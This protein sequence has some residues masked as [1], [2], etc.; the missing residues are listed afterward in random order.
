MSNIMVQGS[1][2]INLLQNGDNLNAS[3]VATAPLYQTFKKGTEDYSPNW[4]TMPD[5]DRPIVYPRVYSAMEAVVLPVTDI[6]WKFNA[7]AMTFDESRLC[8]YPEIAAGKIREIDYNG[9]K[10]LKIVGNLAS[11]INNDSDTISFV[12]NASA[13]GQQMTVSSEITILIEEA[14]SNLYRL[15]LNMT[16]DVIDGDEE[17]LLM[18]AKIY[19]LGAEVTS[20]VEY[21]FSKLD[22]TILRAK[23]SANFTITRAMIDSE[24]MIVCKAY[25]DNTVVAQGHRQVWDSTDPFTVYC[26]QG[27][28]VSQSSKV[29]TN[30]TFSLFNTRTGNVMS[31]ATFDIKA[32]AITQNMQEITSEFTKTSNSLLV[33]G[34]KQVI[35]KA[36]HLT[37]T[38][39]IPG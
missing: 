11:E 22:G 6:S 17:S 16:D 32:Y 23:G 2:T 29:D 25:I 26:D 9:S 4:A 7:V 3:L 35:Y 12:G 34:A 21:E 24:L 8:T 10:A 19:N 38:A 36:I 20:G 18:V 14:S 13:S 27:R 31:S 28:E 15:F 33:P 37:A 5:G 1:V 39:T 30:Y